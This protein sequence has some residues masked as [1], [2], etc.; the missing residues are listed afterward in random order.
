MLF[1][2]AASMSFMSSCSKDEKDSA[3]N[4]N[5]NSNSSLVGT[6]WTHYYGS[7]ETEGSTIRFATETVA[8]W[9]DWE[10]EN[11]EYVEDVDQV[12]YYYNAPNG[13]FTRSGRSVN[14]TI[15]GNSMVVTNGSESSIY[16][17]Q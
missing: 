16:T 11:G 1:A 7:N 10:Y 12:N 17:K 3:N 8:Y 2:F 15:N 13:V 9:S 14:F 4:S 5:G 6:S